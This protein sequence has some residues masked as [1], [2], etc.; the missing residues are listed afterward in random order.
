MRTPPPE[1]SPSASE[2]ATEAAATPTDDSGV[3]G[4]NSVGRLADGISSA[5]TCGNALVMVSEGRVP[6]RHAAEG[7]GGVAPQRESRTTASTCLHGPRS[8][9]W[10][11]HHGHVQ[12]QS[13]ST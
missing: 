11:P 5:L 2:P 1:R 4:Y 6:V 3:W 13:P 8:A 9:P 12:R 7:T 10:R